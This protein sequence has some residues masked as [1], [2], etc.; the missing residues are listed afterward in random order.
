[1]LRHIQLFVA[2]WT[3]ACQALLSM[4][5]SR[6][7]YWSGVPFLFQGIF[8]TQRSNP[9]FLHIL[10]WQADY[11]LLVHPGKLHL[12]KVYVCWS[13]SHV[14]LFATPWTV[15][16]Q[17]L[18]MRFSRQE[19]WS[20]LPFPSPGGLPDLGIEPSSPSFEANSLPSEPPG[21]PNR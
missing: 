2:L 12:P 17:T 3:V 4:E 11:L 16:H 6:Q 20:G 8:P 7:E 10:H 9:C 21:K 13:L 18:S 5:L 15:A 1:M 19:Y 14:K